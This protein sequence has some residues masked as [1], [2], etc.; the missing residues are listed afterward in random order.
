MLLAYLDEIG[1]P[2]AF[3]HPSHNRYADSPAFGYGG[4]VLPEGAAREFTNPSCIFTNVRLG[5]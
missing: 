2:G 4:F 1:A 5:T 3:V